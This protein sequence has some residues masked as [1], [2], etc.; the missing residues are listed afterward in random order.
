M[1]ASDV[2][3]SAD[4]ASCL[5]F[6]FKRVSQTGITSYSTISGVFY[7]NQYRPHATGS[8]FTNFPLVCSGFA[9]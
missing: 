1:N 7:Q 9:N 4:H 2:L 3:H 8:H 5:L 6:F